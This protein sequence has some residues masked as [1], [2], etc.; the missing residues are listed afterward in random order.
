MTG[1]CQCRFLDV[2]QGSSNVIL[3]GKGRA[4]VID[5]GPASCAVCVELLQ[6]Y[7][8]EI[9]VLVLSHSHK[10]HA[11]G[12]ARTIAAFHKKIKR[13]LFLDDGPPVHKH[14]LPLID[15]EVQAGHIPEPERLEATASPSVIWQEDDSRLRVMHPTFRVNLQATEPNATSAIIT[16]EH[17]NNVIVFGGDALHVA[18]VEL[19][20]RIGKSID[21]D[22]L[23]VSHH[24]GDLGSPD[25][26]QLYSTTVRTKTAVVS[27][28]TSNTYKH[29]KPNHLQGLAASGARIMCTQ[30]T[31]QCCGDLESV[32]PGVIPCDRYC[33]SSPTKS[34]TNSGNSREVACAGTV[35]VDMSDDGVHVHSSDIHKQGVESLA[36]AGHSPLCVLSSGPQFGPK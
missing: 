2:G 14:L 35:I 1:T 30:M 27:V 4:I 25:Y 11:G 13:V 32:R 15:C 6:R 22:A 17:K 21:C 16:F 36:R 28:G 8:S 7:V 5:C 18:W 24:G 29:P 31:N 12:A 26:T 20:N 33:R 10:D 3:L 23:S 34:T 9:D 19:S